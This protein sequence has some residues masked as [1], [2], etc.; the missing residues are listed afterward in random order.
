[1]Y[2]VL[3]TVAVLA[4]LVLLP[5]GALDFRT[6]TEAPVANAG[7]DAIIGTG[8]SFTFDGSASSDDKGI[9][10]YQWSVDYQ[11]NVFNFHGKYATFVF[12]KPGTFDVTLTVID[13]AGKEATDT[14]TVTVT[15]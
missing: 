15:T 5:P 12:D 1:V 13:G 8:S 10:D 7:P 11:P 6:D 2:I 3:I 4:V 14:M 9:V